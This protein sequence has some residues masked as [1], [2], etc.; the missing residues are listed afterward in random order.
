MQRLRSSF[1]DRIVKTEER[2]LLMND[3]AGAQ[4]ASDDL[5]SLV[6]FPSSEWASDLAATALPETWDD[7]DSGRHHILTSYLRYYTRRV[8]VE[9]LWAEATSPK[10]RKVAA[11]NTGLLSK[12]FEPIYAMF[13][14][15]HNTGRQP[16]VHKEW[17]SPSSPRLRDFEGQELREAVFFNEP[18][19][20]VY[21]PRLPIVPNLEH[22]IDDNVDRYPDA[23][24][25]SAHLRRA[26]LESAIRVAGAKARTNWRLAAP[27]FYWP[28]TD[29]VGRVQL[30]LPLSLIDPEKVDLALVVDR[31]PAYADDP[32]P[33][34]ASYRAYTV[35]PLEWAYRNARLVTRPEAYWLDIDAGAT[36][37]A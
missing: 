12:H 13:E 19:E 17:A 22:I 9:G 10:G 28:A 32:R 27:Q 3:V 7:D 21:D 35:L 1:T 14:G 26:A 15:N 5:F 11:F 24:R 2:G 29:P 30:L 34:G 16:W 37:A 36:V 23:L 20:V 25:E 31:A 33:D 4:P 6:W 18:G 8:I